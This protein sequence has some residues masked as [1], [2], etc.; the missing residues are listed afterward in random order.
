[1]HVD[2]TLSKST[3]RTSGQRPHPRYKLTENATMTLTLL[4]HPLDLPASSSA[5]SVRAND[6]NTFCASA[7]NIELNKHQ[8]EQE[9]PDPEGETNATYPSGQS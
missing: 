8:S 1:M 4:V 2:G 7:F 5:G 3:S 9:D 6:R